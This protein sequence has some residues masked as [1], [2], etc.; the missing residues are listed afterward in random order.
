MPY[1]PADTAFLRNSALRTLNTEQAAING[2]K[3][4]LDAHFDRACELILACQGRVVVTG[5]ANPAISVASSPRLLPA[6]A[7]RLFSYT[8]AKPA[9]VI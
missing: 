5:M 3:A 6:P 7:H 9:T 2:L 4:K 1:S 8:R